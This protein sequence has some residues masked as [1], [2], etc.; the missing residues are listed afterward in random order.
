MESSNSKLLKEAYRQYLLGTP[1]SEVP[2]EEDLK[3]SLQKFIMWSNLPAM[4]IA[5]KMP[6]WSPDLCAKMRMFGRSWRRALKEYP[7]KHCSFYARK[8]TAETKA[9]MDENKYKEFLQF[10]E[11][12]LTQRKSETFFR[13]Q[14]VYSQNFAMIKKF[15]HLQ[16]SG[17][18]LNLI[19]LQKALQIDRQQ[20]KEIMQ[21]VEK[22][23]KD[24][25]LKEV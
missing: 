10:V 21:V 19:N 2:L 23:K 4:E 7:K 9:V 16:K 12:R 25:C 5:Q 17:V 8:L 20:A 14:G 3:K 6:E 11:I 15:I 22:Y 1:L 24:K 13:Q 18:A